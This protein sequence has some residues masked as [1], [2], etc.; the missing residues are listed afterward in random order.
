[1]GEIHTRLTME[2]MRE[3]VQSSGQKSMV[4]SRHSIRTMDPNT[5]NKTLTT[6]ALFSNSVRH[7]SAAVWY[8]RQMDSIHDQ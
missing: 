7:R 6:S 3:I 2:D 4:K 1:M 8:L 5:S